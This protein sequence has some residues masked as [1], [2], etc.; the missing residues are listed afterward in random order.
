MTERKLLS[1]FILA[2]GIYITGFSNGLAQ[3][4]ISLKNDNAA[5][6]REAEVPTLNALKLNGEESI[7]LDGKLDEAIWQQTQI[8]SGFTQRSPNDGQPATEKTEAKVIYTNNAIYIGIKAF[9]SA[10]DSVAATLFRKDGFAYSDWVYVNID[11]YNDNRTSF[12]FAVNP[13]GVRKDILTYNN[14]NED[15]RWDAIW[16]AKT[17]I[18][19]DHWTVEI[20]IPL[21]QLRFNAKNDIQ[22]WGIN[23]QRRIARKE[24]ISFWSP[25]PQSTSGFVSRYGNLEGITNLEEPRRLEIVP[26]ASTS[27]TRAPGSAANPFYKS[28]DVAASF[29][30]DIKYGLTS[31]FTLTGTINPDFGQVEADPAVINLSAF[32]IFFPEQRPFFLEGSDIFQFGNTQTF[33]KFG[34]PTIFYSRRIGRQPQ[35]RVAAAGVEAENIDRPDQTSIASAAKVSGKTANGLSIGV[36]NAFTTRENATF[37]NTSNNERDL[38]I[39]PPTNYF[40]GRVKKDFNKG[41][42]IIGGYVSSVNRFINAEYL[43]SNLHQANYIGG[44]DFEHSWNDREWIASGQ[45][46]GSHVK[47]SQNAIRQTQL[48]SSRYFN[49]VDAAYLSVDENKTSLSGYSGELSFARFGG[50]HWRGSLT[51]SMVNPGYEVNDIGF[52]TR[53]DFH[54]LSYLLQYHEPA[55]S[56]P[57][58]FYNINIYGN[59]RWNFG[60]NKTFNSLASSGYV[61]FTNLWSFNF[62]T[63]Y[64]IGAFDDRLL[65][66]GPLARTPANFSYSG[67]IES[68]QSN[69]VSAAI[70]HLR[71]NDRSGGMERDFFVDLTVR[72]TSYIQFTLSPNYNYRTNTSQYILEQPDQTAVNTF[73]RR[74]VLSDL[75]Q[76]TFSA[77][78]RLDW[79]FTPDI[80]LQTYIR[81]FIT[82]G[83]YYNYKE[84]T[85]PRE[86]DFSIYGRDAGTI[87]ESDG[88]FT[89]DPDGQGAANP[90]SFSDRDFNFR[91]IQINAV[92]RW[93]Y[94]P[95]AI[96]FLVWQQDRQSSEQLSDL[97]FN[98]DIT[99]LFDTKPTYF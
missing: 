76:T 8:A 58:R 5:K 29:G 24:E 81:P 66:G 95:G 9:D 42:T 57:F 85:T 97:R 12:S 30:G 11:S 43:E 20:R 91:S 50:K 37:I 53:A 84:F 45:F 79:T 15:S 55:P 40:V 78:L 93:E 64:N 90:F 14:S 47:G 83:D 2:I 51:Y 73:G 98:R 94:T 67:V 82:N 75:D 23:F 80:S 56:G 10:M 92:F 54:G 1:Y 74:Y 99:R 87:N 68:N 70:G 69:M 13:R 4:N 72:P 34:T 63:T 25:T 35:G 31:D 27:L 71:R 26:Y 19:D 6:S 60:G 39:E 44:I 52:E 62:N 59:Q 49:R 28:N 21:S 89:V 88:V 32:E 65:R 17:E 7:K 46:S 77:A 3:E 61:Q 18:N 33:N 48:N 38:S 86:F 16:E 36:L 22:H 41:N 96:L